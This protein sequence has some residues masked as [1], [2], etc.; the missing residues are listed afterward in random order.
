ME[1]EAG[2]N[3]RIPVD[4]V[5]DLLSSAMGSYSSFLLIDSSFSSTALEFGVPHSPGCGPLFSIQALSPG[6]LIQSPAFK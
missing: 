5:F 1:G 4:K 3:H 6:N 2:L